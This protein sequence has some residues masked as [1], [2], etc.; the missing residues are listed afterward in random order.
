MTL[1]GSLSIMRGK[2]FD[3]LSVA[4]KSWPVSIVCVD[5][6]PFHSTLVSLVACALYA[7]SCSCRF[8]S[9]TAVASSFWSVY[10]YSAL[11]DN[12]PQCVHDFHTTASMFTRNFAIFP[13]RPGQSHLPLLPWHGVLDVNSLSLLLRSSWSTTHS[14]FANQNHGILMVVGTHLTISSSLLRVRFSSR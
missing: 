4:L 12:R 2:V 13:L 1:T 10:M 14:V 6:V 9:I 5:F 7:F 3:S 8:A 11:Y